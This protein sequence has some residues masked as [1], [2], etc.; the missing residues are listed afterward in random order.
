MIYALYLMSLFMCL[1][2]KNSDNACVALP[3]LFMCSILCAIASIRYKNLKSRI[4]ALEEKLKGGAK[5]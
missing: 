2:Y 3:S 1:G 4:K 5:E